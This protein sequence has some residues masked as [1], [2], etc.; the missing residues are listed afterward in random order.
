[1]PPSVPLR[2]LRA[3][4]SS[5]GPVQRSAG[6]RLF[7]IPATGRGAV[8][9]AHAVH[10]VYAASTRH[11]SAAEGFG[12]GLA[13]QAEGTLV[14]IHEDRGRH[15]RGTLYGSG[16]R[17]WGVETNALLLVGVPDTAALLAAGEEALR[18]GAPAAV[19]MSGW[20]ESRAWS[21]TAS[22]RLAL[23]AAAGR[24]T[25]I[26]VRTGAQPQPSAS[27]TRWSVSSTPSRALEAGAPGRPAFRVSLL[28]SRAGVAPGEWIMEWDRDTRSF[29][30][31][32][33][34][35]DLV[36]APAHRPA[37]IRAA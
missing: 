12:L 29:V 19:L 37:G 30:E 28:R 27:D 5:P 23:A 2:Q 8:F 36:S 10:E 3:H 7:D 4:L 15:E 13:L 11:G 34:S 24:T 33:T 32:K 17:E 18:S 22:R 6:A 9:P 20:G 35:G 31:P 14:W 26:F 1:M 25:A 16:L 21:L